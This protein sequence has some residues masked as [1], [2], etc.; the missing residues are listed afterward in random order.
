M[1][2]AR[3]TP[4]QP[5]PIFLKRCCS[6]VGGKVAERG[7][8]VGDGQAVVERS[9]PQ[10]VESCADERGDKDAV[11]INDVI[12]RDAVANDVAS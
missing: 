9:L 11:N 6:W 4:V 5:L 7:S 10:A 2:I 1:P 8:A 12:V 3:C